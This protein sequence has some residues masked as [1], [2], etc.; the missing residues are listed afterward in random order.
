MDTENQQKSASI[1]STNAASINN[2]P[3]AHF[4]YLK[5]WYNYVNEFNVVK[6]AKAGYDIAKHSTAL[7]ENAFNKVENGIQTGLTNV[8]APVY[9]NYCYPATDRIL[10]YYNKSV[11]TTKCA[12]DKA[13]DATSYAAALSIGLAVVATQMGVLVTTSA[14]NAF[15]TSLLYTKQAGTTALESA[16]HARSNVENIIHSALEQSQKIAK[17]PAEKA[18]EHANTFL[19]VANTV[20]DRLLGLPEASEPADSQISDRIIF[21]SNRV[22]KFCHSEIW[23][24]SNIV[25][26]NIFDSDDNED[27][28]ERLHYNIPNPHR[29]RVIALHNGA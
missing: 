23:R 1:P 28:F 13:F 26:E 2:G 17:V 22:T 14:V 6:T 18:N 15:L 7:T 21:L 20:F 27:F 4:D 8:A 16:A 3:N 5:G 9:A 29:Q 11:D 24:G 10:Q 12:A 25:V 19:D